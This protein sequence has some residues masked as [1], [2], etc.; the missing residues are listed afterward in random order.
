MI[1]VSR[2]YLKQSIKARKKFEYLVFKVPK[3]P[4]ET[5]V[6]LIFDISFLF[7]LV[8]Q[9]KSYVALSPQ[10]NLSGIIKKSQEIE[11]FFSKSIF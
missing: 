10:S 8:P 9:S 1:L 5:C 3:S 6:T 7:Q 11:F 4:Q 2:S